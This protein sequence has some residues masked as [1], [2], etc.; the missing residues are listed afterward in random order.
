MRG[1]D[2]QPQGYE[3]RAKVIPLGWKKPMKNHLLD[4]DS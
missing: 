4:I 1:K 2:M 3:G